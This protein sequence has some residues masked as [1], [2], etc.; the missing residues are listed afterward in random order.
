M[1]GLRTARSDKL[2]DRQRK[3]GEA[4]CKAREEAAAEEN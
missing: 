4:K 3:K 2:M 1:Q